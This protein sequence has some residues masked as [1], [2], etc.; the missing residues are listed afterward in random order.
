MP[1]DDEAKKV[2]SNDDEV[3]D[4]FRQ[5][6]V[7]PSATRT[8]LLGL[9]AVA[10]ASIPVYLYSAVFGLS[11]QDHFIVF[12]V[13]TLLSAV[14]LNL[15]YQNLAN[16][17]VN[18]LTHQRQETVTRQAVDAEARSKGVK[19]DEII[20]KKRAEVATRTATEMAAYSVAYNNTLFLLATAAFSVYVFSGLPTQ[21]GY[22][23]SVLLAAALALVLAK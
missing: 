3:F 7:K 16:S 15:A 10:T 8:A 22:I 13:V 1:S 12:G 6:E 14:V 5:T 19:H 9:Q 4:L 21:Y 17:A 18:K 2:K 11:L 23:L 20:K